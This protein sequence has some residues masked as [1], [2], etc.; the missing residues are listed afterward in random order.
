M[1]VEVLSM[2]VCLLFFP[3]TLSATQQDVPSSKP[4]HAKGQQ[5]LKTLKDVYYYNNMS[6]DYSSGGASPFDQ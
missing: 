4:D 1:R 5:H 6:D 2:G 3:L